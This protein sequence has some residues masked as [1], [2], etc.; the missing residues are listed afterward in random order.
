MPLYPHVSA[1]NIPPCRTPHCLFVILGLLHLLRSWKEVN[2]WLWTPS[3]VLFVKG[4]R[5]I[6]SGQPSRET[7]DQLLTTVNPRINGGRFG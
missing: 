7:L 5:T 2:K 3:P 1:D 6:L 4:F